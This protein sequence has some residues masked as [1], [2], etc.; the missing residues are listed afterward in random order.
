MRTKRPDDDGPYKGDYVRAFVDDYQREYGFTL[1]DRPVVVDNIRVRVIGRTE[2]I[3]RIPIP[4]A[5]EN[6][7]PPIDVGEVYF[8]ETG[9]IKTPIFDLSKLHAGHEV[10]G[11]AVIIEK[12]NTIVVLPNCKAIITEYGDVRITVGKEGKR[13]VG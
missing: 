3:R 9:R 4:K 7:P 10:E 2:S 11:P 1:T 6:P 12:T 8:M 13:I 5:T